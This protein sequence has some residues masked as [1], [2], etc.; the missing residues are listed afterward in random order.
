MQYNSFNDL[1]HMFE[2]GIIMQIFNLEKNNGKVEITCYI[3]IKDM[4]LL[5][6]LGIKLNTYEKR[7]EYLVTR[8]ITEAK[9]F[10]R[11]TNVEDVATIRTNASIIFD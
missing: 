6:E 3:Q 8:D 11:I 1:I 10:V 9:S 4:E 7:W 2:G 5:N